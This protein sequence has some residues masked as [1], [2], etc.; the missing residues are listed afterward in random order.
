M[1][2]QYDPC[3]PCLCLNSTCKECIFGNKTI[4]EREALLRK[5]VKERKNRQVLRSFQFHYGMVSL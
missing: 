2:K 4:E 3:D 5:T 1:N